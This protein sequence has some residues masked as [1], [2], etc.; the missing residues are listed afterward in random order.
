MADAPAPPWTLACPWCS[1]SILV[2]ARGQ[3]G[4]DPG[5]GV[6]AAELMA[7]HA[8]RRHGKTWPEFLREREA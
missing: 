1:F 6:E 4:G 8:G 2:F 7:A 3:R 5:S